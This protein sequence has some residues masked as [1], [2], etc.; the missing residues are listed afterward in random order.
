MQPLI[1]KWQGAGLEG[2]TTDI[3]VAGSGVGGGADIEVAG[4]RVGGCSHN[5]RR[6]AQ[7]LCGTIYSWF[8]G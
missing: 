5:P 3:E 4:G 8:C 6:S 1:L 7:C 2:A